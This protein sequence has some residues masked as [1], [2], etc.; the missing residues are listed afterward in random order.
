MKAIQLE[1]PKAFREIDLP[2][3]A[4]PGPGDAVVRVFRVGVC[5]TD[6]SG[7]L[8]KMPFFSYPRI[9]GH[10]LGVEVVAVGD[11]VTNVKPG[12]K[13]AVEPYI[14]CQ[15]C[16]SCARGHTNCCENH[17]TL[18]VH[19][20]G[21]LRPL[22]TVPARKLHVSTKLSFEQLALVETLGIGLHAI[23]RSNPRADETVFVIGAGPIGLSV[24]EFAKLAGAH[25]IVMDL[26]EQRLAFV[27]EKMGVTETILSKGVLEDDVKTFTDLTNGKLGNVVV[28]ATGSARSMVS[29]YNFVG[30]TGRLVWVGITQ[31]PLTLTQPLMHRRE[32]TFMAS[33]NALSHEFTRIIRLIE[34]GMLNTNPWITHR[35][36]MSDL[37][38]VFPTWLKPE[39]GV[40]KA[41]VEVN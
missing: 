38:G 6:Y 18:G 10:E 39:A 40:V 3:P 4:Q 33:R 35:A 21:G 31:D 8:G 20:D 7:Y 17:Q 5:G 9:P 36:P 29:A 1:Q 14:N 22:F 30:F 26:N 2:E 34:G 27:R 24:I 16:Y 13:A 23:N 28:D 12:D 41:M 37:I 15:R 25:I 32:M 19:V 11:G